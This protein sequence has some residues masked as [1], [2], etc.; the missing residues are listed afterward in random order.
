M[1]SIID[2]VLAEE[3]VKPVNKTKPRIKARTTNKSFTGF[4]QAVSKKKREDGSH[5]PPS[6]TLDRKI[7]QRLH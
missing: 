3:K 7:S 1:D 5:V 2:D 6:R 4:K